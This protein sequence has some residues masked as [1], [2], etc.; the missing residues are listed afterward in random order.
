MSDVAPAVTVRG[1]LC[2]IDTDLPLLRK[3]SFNGFPLL[4]P[5]ALAKRLNTAGP[6]SHRLAQEVAAELAQR[7]P[8]A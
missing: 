6:V 2:F 1:A 4:H 7:F 3:L 8:S 5:R